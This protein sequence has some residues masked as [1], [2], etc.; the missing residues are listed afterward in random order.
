VTSPDQRSSIERLVANAR[1]AR[2]PFP[3][4]SEMGMIIWLLDALTA[5]EAERDRLRDN[6]VPPTHCSICSTFEWQ[7]DALPDGAALIC[8][9]HGLL[10]PGWAYD[11]GELIEE[12]RRTLRTRLNIEQKLNQQYGEMRQERDQALDDRDR[13]AREIRAAQ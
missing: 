8:K 1:G 9:E 6:L 7:G 2:P 12:L 13:L 4:D 5:T 10:A 3:P 11:N